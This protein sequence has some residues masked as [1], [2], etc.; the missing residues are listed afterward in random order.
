MFEKILKIRTLTGIFHEF[1][2][3]WVKFRR[4]FKEDDLSSVKLYVIL[5]FY[6]SICPELAF[7]SE[8]L[9]QYLGWEVIY[10][11]YLL[12][13]NGKLLHIGNNWWCFRK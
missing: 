12:R 3:K 1:R 5:D 11:N 8:D 6:Y 2:P 9:A 7:N 10:I 13:E 4:K